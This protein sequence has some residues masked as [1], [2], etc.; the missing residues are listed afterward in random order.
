MGQLAG[1]KYREIVKRLKALGLTFHRR[2]SRTATQV[3]PVAAQAVHPRRI[4]TRSQQRWA[5]TRGSA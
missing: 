4:V 3:E 2:V 1:Y 5:E